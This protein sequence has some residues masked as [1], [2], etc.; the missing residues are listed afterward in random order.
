MLDQHD[1][2]LLR[3]LFAEQ[4]K[5]FLAAIK[6]N[7][8]DLKREIRDEVHALISASEQRIKT[9]ITANIAELLDNAILPQI[10][11]L[12]RDMTLVKQHLQL[13]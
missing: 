11:D 5:R 1:I 10:A 4:D 13:V 12:Q 7:N 3:G 9:E 8:Q 6:T 2:E